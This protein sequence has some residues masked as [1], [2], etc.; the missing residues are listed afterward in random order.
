MQFINISYDKWLCREKI[1][2]LCKSFDE[3]Q[4][5][6]IVFVY[7]FH[8]HCMHARFAHNFTQPKNIY[9]FLM[10]LR[11]YSLPNSPEAL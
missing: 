2:E 7:V 11:I 4:A 3:F 9:P 8:L 10:Y 1:A 6:F 5:V